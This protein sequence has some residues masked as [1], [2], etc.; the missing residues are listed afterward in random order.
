M[1]KQSVFQAEDFSQYMR[2]RFH[3]DELQ[4]LATC[5]NYAQTRGGGLVGH[6]LILLA[7]KLLHVL[8]E[9]G[10]D[11]V[12]ERPRYELRT[13]KDIALPSGVLAAGSV[14]AEFCPETDDCAWFGSVAFSK[15]SA[16][17]KHGVIPVHEFGILSDATLF[18]WRPYRSLFWPSDIEANP[19]GIGRIVKIAK[20]GR[21]YDR[22]F[23]SESVQ[24]L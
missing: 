19:D 11:V 1:I 9:N 4:L 3:P 13:L 8:E 6:D 7:H 10:C 23:D 14:S 5:W 18:E 20:N 2:N 22:A 12:V 16:E 21:D 17:L 15:Y 24:D